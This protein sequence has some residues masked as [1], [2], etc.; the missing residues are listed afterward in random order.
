MP[1]AKS[2]TEQLV[3]L[4]DIDHEISNSLALDDINTEEILAIVDRREQLLQSLLSYI[5][6][7]PKF[8]ESPEWRSAVQETQRIVELMQSKTDQFGQALH[9]YRYGKK[10]VQQYKKFL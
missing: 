3:L 5:E 8:A 7:S 9:K 2:F 1:L 4:S 10:S 6:S